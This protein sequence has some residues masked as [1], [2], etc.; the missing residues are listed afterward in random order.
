MEMDALL[1]LAVL[2]GAVALFVTEKLPVDV[3][4]M[5]VLASLLVLGLVTPA[6]ALSG[7]SSEATI[8]VAAMFVLSAG[9]QASGALHSVGRLLAKVRWASRS[10]LTMPSCA[11]RWQ[12]NT[13]QQLPAGLAWERCVVWRSGCGVQYAAGV[14]LPAP[15]CEF[16]A[17]IKGTSDAPH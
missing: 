9:L 10:G 1:T 8:T 7:F 17:S 6:E 5:L 2:V 16:H 15:S 11:L 12:H 13:V 14:F 3:V 4:A